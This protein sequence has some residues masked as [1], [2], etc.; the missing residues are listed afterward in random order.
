MEKKNIF[1]GSE[2]RFYVCECFFF[3]CEQLQ[4]Q[5]QFFFRLMLR[6]LLGL[7]WKKC[8]NSPNRM[9]N[10]YK[11]SFLCQFSYENFHEINNK[12]IKT[13]KIGKFN[14][15]FTNWKLC[16]ISLFFYFFFILGNYKKFLKI[17]NFLFCN[18]FF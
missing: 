8:S 14:K 16:R 12:I 17:R 10:N 9:I 15:I 5:P 1:N 7:V 3:I 11:C 13:G 18:F 2:I 6:Q 4:I